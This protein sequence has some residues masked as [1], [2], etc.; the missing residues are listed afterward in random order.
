MRAGFPSAYPLPRG[1]L[2]RDS[3]LG[4]FLAGVGFALVELASRPC[5]KVVKRIR[6]TQRTSASVLQTWFLQL[7]LFCVI[8]LGCALLAHLSKVGHFSLQDF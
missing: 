3:I 2:K 6:Q 7:R 1:T 8:R 5:D 4:I